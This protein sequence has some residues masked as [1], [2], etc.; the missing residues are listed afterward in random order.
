MFSRFFLYKNP[1]F[2][3]IYNW[4]GNK[5]GVCSKALPGE[6]SGSSGGTLRL[7]PISL[8]FHIQGSSVFQH[9]S[10]N[11]MIMKINMVRK[12]IQ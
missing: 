11:M 2:L 3:P 4:K 1:G 6:A 12:A 8:V 5:F 10:L 9:I 7:T